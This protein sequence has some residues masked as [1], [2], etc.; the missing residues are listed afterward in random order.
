M[1]Q[2]ED[3]ADAAREGDE[4]TACVTMVLL[5]K[6]LLELTLDVELLLLAT[7]DACVVAD[8]GADAAVAAGVSSVR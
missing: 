6:L 3:A 8:D 1:A 5:F 7:L 4:T 2:S